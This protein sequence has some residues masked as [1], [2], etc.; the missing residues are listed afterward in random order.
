MAVTRRIYISM[1]ADRWLAPNQN[2]LK[3]AI[4]ADIE[5]RGYATEVFFDPRGKPSLAGGQAWSAVAAD[6]VM[7]RCVGAVLIGMPRWTLAQA[8]DGYDKL[9]TEYCSY[10]GA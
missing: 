4:V 5:R 8:A 9:A 2:A 6:R 1:P 7:R 10:E 3:W